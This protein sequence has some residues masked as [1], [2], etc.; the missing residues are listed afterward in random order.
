VAGQKKPNAWGLYDMHGG[1]CEWC[2]DW[3]GKDYYSQSTSEDPVGPSAGYDRV[4]RGGSWIMD[5]SHCRSA[6]RRARTPNYRSFGYGFRVVC[7]Q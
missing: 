6:V 5:A 1:V 4:L 3:Y 7:V 2:A